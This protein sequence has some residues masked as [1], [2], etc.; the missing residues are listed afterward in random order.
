[1]DVLIL[2][3]IDLLFFI[4]IYEGSSNREERWRGQTSP[5]VGNDLRETYITRLNISQVFSRDRLDVF[6]FGLRSSPVSMLRSGPSHTFA[7]PASS[8]G[9][10]CCLPRCS[11]SPIGRLGSSDQSCDPA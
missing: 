9:I 8:D 10:L 2:S 6:G 11:V 1:M 5:S 7:K 4:V 3:G